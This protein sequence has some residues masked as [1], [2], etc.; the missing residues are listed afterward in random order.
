MLHETPPQDDSDL[1]QKVLQ[2]CCDAYRPDC[3][4]IIDLLAYE[5]MD[6]LCILLVEDDP[7]ITRAWSLG[8]NQSGYEVTPTPSLSAA[9]RLLKHRSFDAVIIDVQLTDGSGLDLLRWMKTEGIPIKSL[10]VTARQDQESA[11]LALQRGATE[12]IRKPVGP[13]ELVTRLDR[14]FK[15]TNES[16]ITMVRYGEISLLEETR[17]VFCSE[18][19]IHLTPSEYLI[20]R[21]LLRRAGAPVSR[22]TLLQAFSASEET[23][24]RAIDSHISRIRSKVGLASNGRYSIESVWGSGYRLSTKGD[25]S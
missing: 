23:S 9:Q 14:I 5:L 19:P 22:E 18:H 17:E 10:V 13:I 11:V 7:L 16:Q 20:F 4:K 15:Y 1:N 24:E 3:T 8:L 6:T 25:P 21:L 2:K 12:F